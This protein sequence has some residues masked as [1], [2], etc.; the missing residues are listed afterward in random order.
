MSTTFN[1]APVPLSNKKVNFC[2]CSRLTFMKKKCQRKCLREHYSKVSEGLTPV[3]PI[4]SG[5]HLRR[6]PEHASSCS[7]VWL[8]PCE[9]LIC[10]YIILSYITVSIFRNNILFIY[11]LRYLQLYK[12]VLYYIFMIP[13]N[14][15]NP[16]FSILCCN[17]LHLISSLTL[18]VP[19]NM[20]FHY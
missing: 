20:N 2:T 19:S 6:S 9:Y 16:S 4:A 17:L 18:Q 3:L 12:E 10:L 8:R 11:P 13:L 1:L 5:S 15:L 7:E 14:P